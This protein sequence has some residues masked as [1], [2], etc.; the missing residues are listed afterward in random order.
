ML[1]VFG[2]QRFSKPNPKKAR[3]KA[4]VLDSLTPD[5]E[6][7]V[8]SV[9]NKL[10]ASL[11]KR[12]QAYCTEVV[13]GGGANGLAFLETPRLCLASEGG[14]TCF[15]AGELLSALRLTTNLC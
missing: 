11:P 8:Y 5:E 14:I 3:K 6:E 13:L 12:Q 10:P 15:F 7:A 2:K 9:L 1:C 4:N